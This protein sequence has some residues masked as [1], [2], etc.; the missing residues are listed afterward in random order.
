M[1]QSAA[2]RKRCDAAGARAIA[3]A[4]PSCQ[5]AKAP[6]IMLVCHVYSPGTSWRPGE[7]RLLALCSGAGFASDATR[8]VRRL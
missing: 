3:G 7:L 5:T 1:I 6:A 8:L 2:G 4:L